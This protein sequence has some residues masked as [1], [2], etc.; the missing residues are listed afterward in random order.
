MGYNRTTF[1][2]I[3]SFQ[4]LKAEV[5]KL[6]QV[7]VSKVKAEQNRSDSSKP[8]SSHHHREVSIVSIYCQTGRAATTT[9]TSHPVT[10]TNGVCLT[11]S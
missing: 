7:F 11:V 5:N 3:T 1:F 10:N 6:A 8:H 4:Y 2:K 9:T